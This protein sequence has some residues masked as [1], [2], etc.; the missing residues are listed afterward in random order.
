MC[1]YVMCP[2]ALPQQL[3][4]TI[5]AC[6]VLLKAPKTKTAGCTLLSCLYQSMLEAWLCH[7]DFGI[8]EPLSNPQDC[9]SSEQC[10]VL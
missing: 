5:T 1:A 7:F 3:S 6:L 9:L 8:L 10:K 2:Q 4:L